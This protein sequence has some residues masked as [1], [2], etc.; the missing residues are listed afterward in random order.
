MA[1]NRLQIAAAIGRAASCCSACV[2]VRCL[3]SVLGYCGT[4]TEYVVPPYAVCIRMF[5]CVC[6]Y[7]YIY[8]VVYAHIH[9]EQFY[10]I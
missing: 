2:G 3:N 10:K 7:I 6:I 5:V 1:G 8:T 9:V 4:D